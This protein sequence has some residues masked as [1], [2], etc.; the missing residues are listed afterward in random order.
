V[1]PAELEEQGARVGAFGRWLLQE[2]ELRALSREEVARLTKLAPAVIESLESGELAR[3]PPRA[4]LLGYL[5]SYAGAVGLD[6][7]D[8]VLRWQEAAGVEEQ[9]V[10]AAPR[11]GRARLRLALVLLGVALAVGLALVT[12]QRTRRPRA[13][14]LPDRSGRPTERA[15]YVQP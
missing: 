15:P 9:G 8:A 12:W 14:S 11:R 10:A 4:Y 1:T 3:M 13:L 2:R 5:R 7:D 6:A